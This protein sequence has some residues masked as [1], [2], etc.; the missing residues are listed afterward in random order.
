MKIEEKYELVLKAYQNAYAKYSKFKV[1]ALVIVKNGVFFLAVI[2][3]MPP[4]VFLIAQKEVHF[5]Q[6]IQMVFK[7]MILKNLF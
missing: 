5:L 2:L 6:H 4:M 7:K 3:K 1:G